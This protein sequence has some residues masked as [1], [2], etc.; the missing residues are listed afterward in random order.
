MKESKKE[1]IFLNKDWYILFE[2]NKINDK[3]Q[4]GLRLRYKNNGTLFKYLEDS[5]CYKSLTDAK[6]DARNIICEWLDSLQTEKSIKHIP[7]EK[8]HEFI[9][10]QL[11]LF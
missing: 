1:F 6:M 3:Y 9:N 5:I 4:F 10:P 7:L 8:I 11:N 2:H